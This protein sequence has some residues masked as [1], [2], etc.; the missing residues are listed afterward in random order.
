MKIF[1]TG[2]LGFVGSH[3]TERLLKEGHEVTVVNRSGGGAAF[4]GGRAAVITADT[5]LPGQWQNVLADHDVV[6]NLAG[7]TIFTRWTKRAK[8]RILKSRVET[9]R[10]VVA[11]IAASGRAIQLL[12]TS[13]VG[14]YGFRGD[15]EVDERGAGGDDF[16][17]RVSATWEEEALKAVRSG[18]RV[19]LCRYGV[20]FGRN[21]GALSQFRR[22]FSLYAGSVLGSGR[23]W[24]PWI[25]IDDLVS[26][27]SF[28]LSKPDVSGAFNCC[29]PGPVTNRELT[30]TLSRVLGKRVILPPV[31]AFA[32]RILLGELGEF[33]LQGQRAI[34][35]RLTDLG[36]SFKFPLFEPAMRDLAAKERKS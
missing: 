5:T 25:H 32:L 17:A 18:S 33:V 6:I 35:K 29:S 20:V 27:Y 26:I 23:Q 30:D 28:I 1:I 15:E 31:P 34:P 12:S 9:T 16:L 21:G 3:L 19:V 10:N 14:Y 13:A 11:A 4:S 22:I 24:F 8:E 36:Y 2:G 7:A